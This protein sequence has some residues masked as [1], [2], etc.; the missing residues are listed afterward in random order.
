MKENKEVHNVICECGLVAYTCDCDS[1][2]SH[3]PD[4][5]AVMCPKCSDEFYGECE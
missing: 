2:D 5:P 1:P 3:I 4:D